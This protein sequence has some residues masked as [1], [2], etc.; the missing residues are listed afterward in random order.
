MP[1][2]LKN[3]SATYQK[4]ANNMLKEHIGKTMEVYI[5]DMLG[6]SNKSKDHPEHLK[7][8]F[9]II[10]MYIMKLNPSK[11]TFRVVVGFF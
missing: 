6:K 7:Q 1:F 8:T 11:C 4:L 5:Y 3:S 2:G 10:D 9:N